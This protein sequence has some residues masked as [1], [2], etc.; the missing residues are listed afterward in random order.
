MGTGINLSKIVA[1]TSLSCIQLVI[2]L[3]FKSNAMHYS[4]FCMSRFPGQSLYRWTPIYFHHKVWPVA[5]PRQNVKPEAEGR[6][7]G[8][9]LVL[10]DCEFVRVSSYER[11]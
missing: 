7:R 6:N 2:S 11:L 5:K 9:Q 10:D 4:A 1:D 3:F 8:G